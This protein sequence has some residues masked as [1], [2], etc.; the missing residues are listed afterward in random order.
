MY[1][2][3]TFM[4][5]DNPQV[6]MPS[7]WDSWRGRPHFLQPDCPSAKNVQFYNSSP[8]SPVSISYKFL[9]STFQWNVVLSSGIRVVV[10]N[11]ERQPP[12]FLSSAFSI[13]YLLAAKL[14]DTLS[15]LCCWLFILK[16]LFNFF[17]IGVCFFCQLL[18]FTCYA[19][20]G[21]VVK[22]RI[23]QLLWL[24]KSNCP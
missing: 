17:P 24:K 12:S 14:A 18:L 1:I 6:V 9:R 13:Q 15:N 23:F 16:P 11:G 8:L 5:A 19:T 7:A 20:S 3:L 22:C 10:L 2:K 21:Y 4:S